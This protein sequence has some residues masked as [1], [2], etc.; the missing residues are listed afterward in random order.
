MKPS[1]PSVR[2]RLLVCIIGACSVAFASLVGSPARHASERAEPSQ[3]SAL[4]SAAF[5][6]YSAGL[7]DQCIQLNYR[8]YDDAMHAERPTSAVRFLNN[9][10]S[11]YLVTYRFKQALDVL[12][13]AH[14][15]AR[16]QHDSAMLAAVSSNISSVYLQMFDFKDANI[17]AKEALDS[18][19]AGSLPGNLAQLFTQRALTLA[20]VGQG[21]QSEEY[22]EKAIQSARHD[23]NS[24]TE[25]D[26]WEYL[27]E[28]RFA[29]GD[30]TGAERPLVQAFRMRKLGHLHSLQPSY[31]LLSTLRLRQG[32]LPSAHALADLA[33][34][35]PDQHFGAPLWL[36]HNQRARVLLAEHKPALAFADLR[37]ALA[38][39]RTWRKNV[40]ASDSFRSSVGVRLH[41]VYDSFVEAASQLPG[42]EIEAF[43]AAE[44]S[45]TEALRETLAETGN[46]SGNLFSDSTSTE[47]FSPEHA[48]RDIQAGL[49]PGEALISFHLG[50]L[51]SHMW[52]V[53]SNSFE[54]HTLP[55]GKRIGTLAGQFEDA[56]ENGAPDR[57]SLG[58]TLSTVLFHGL[59][60]TIK[61]AHIWLI[62]AEGA[63]SVL[64]FSALPDPSGAAPGTAGYIAER[65]AVQHVASAYF[66]KRTNL[67]RPD[68]NFLG[69]GDAI[70]NTADP[71]WRAS[72]KPPTLLAAM[73]RPGASP[74]VGL[75]LPRLA[76][77]AQE[78]A[79]C[80][81]SWGGPSAPVL[82]TGAGASG[83]AL[84]VALAHK[85]SVVHFAAHFVQPE[86]HPEDVEIHL[87]ISS[88]VGVL[89]F[90]DI[91]RYKVPGSLIVMS[92][93]SS[94]RAGT[95]AGAGVMGLTRAW[96]IAGA[97]SVIGS[98]WATPD[99]TGELFQAFYRNLGRCMRDASASC[100]PAEALQLAKLEMLHSKSW[101]SDPT[102]WAAFYIVGKE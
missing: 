54:T 46:N 42:H 67:L 33:I 39:I 82:L 83:K 60:S 17:A 38:D 93:C 55:A 89:R 50:D 37:A 35:T 30:Y 70:Y 62:S 7:F 40:V 101:R 90:G 47:K 20:G 71:R 1:L 102:Y 36:L 66:L 44:E 12:L 98:R 73:F 43:S 96:L 77:S 84:E 5:H 58:R 25:A 68:G 21:L 87:G 78:I 48:L 28:T 76:G 23:A 79:N 4:R 100:S 51:S 56:V 27:G 80:A 69:V 61:Q 91:A 31:I 53:S 10:G 81:R 26:A 63:L 94:A 15:L 97:S 24:G 16:S 32:D 92:G 18:L 45:R 19:G 8:G 2:R 59:G 99:D 49:A 65:Y 41:D 13:R 9:I 57:D 14:E 52:A 95:F 29:S 22:F 75:Q 34:N 86:N 88:D 85:T 64:P 11:A 72:H 3:L 74:D 6:L